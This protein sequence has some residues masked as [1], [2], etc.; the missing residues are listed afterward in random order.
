MLLQNYLA[1]KKTTIWFEMVSM[2]GQSAAL[3]KN[4]EYAELSVFSAYSAIFARS[5]LQ[6]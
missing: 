6:S 4:A 3:I 5:A 2:R 1:K